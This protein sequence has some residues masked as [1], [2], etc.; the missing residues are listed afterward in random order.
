[1]RGHSTALDD[2]VAYGNEG[3][4]DAASRFDATRGVPFEAFARSRIHGAIVDGIRKEGW[5]GRRAYR[6]LNTGRVGIV[7]STENDPRSAVALPTGLTI[8]HAGHRAWAGGE[9]WLGEI[10]ERGETARG[11]RWNGRRMAQPPVDD[12]G[13]LHTLATANLS[14]L[15]DRE[16]RLL[17]LRYF[18]DK[19]LSQV[20]REMGF[21]RSWA[22]R[23]HAR[24]LATL[25]AAIHAHLPYRR[26]SVI[27]NKRL[28]TPRPHRR[29]A[30]Q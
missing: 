2:L 22:S 24:A 17:E 5:F 20:A 6:R 11:A 21:R 9:D 3:L 14:L 26:R 13:G 4:L 8:L 12:E 15:P 23:L 25:G 1:M 18:H 16:R 27:G 10:L 19:T 30:S 28:P 29:S 7:D